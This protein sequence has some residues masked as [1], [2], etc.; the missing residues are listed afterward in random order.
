MGAPKT[1][2]VAVPAISA[3]WFCS[4]T[5]S[6]FARTEAPVCGARKPSHRAVSPGALV[7]P[8][9]EK[10]STRSG[11]TPAAADTA[12]PKWLAPSPWALPVSQAMSCAS[13]SENWP[14]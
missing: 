14:T 4:G 1:A 8:S 3:A 11:T 5:I 13:S 2:W 6:A 7:M 12:K 10:P 9:I